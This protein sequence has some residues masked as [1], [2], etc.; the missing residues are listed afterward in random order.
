MTAG[1]RRVLRQQILRMRVWSWLSCQCGGNQNS[2]SWEHSGITIT[3]A[4]THGQ[5]KGGAGGGQAL[6]QGAA[7]VPASSGAVVIV[8]TVE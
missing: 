8:R 1:I 4:F 7:L 3:T 5:L 6:E 2:S